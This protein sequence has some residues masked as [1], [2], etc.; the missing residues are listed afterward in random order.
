VKDQQSNAWVEPKGQVI[1]EPD[2]AMTEAEIVK[3]ESPTTTESVGS[4]VPVTQRDVAE[5]KEP[6]KPG[7]KEEG[8]TTEAAG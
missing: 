8:G 1:T 7:E 6:P 4:P 5:Q 2:T 3:Q